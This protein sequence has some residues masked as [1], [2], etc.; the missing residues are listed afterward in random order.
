MLWAIDKKIQEGKIRKCLFITLSGLKD[1][2]LA[3][4]KTEIP[5]R[6]GIVLK[7]KDH[8]DK[9][10]NKKFKSSKKNLDYDIYISNYESMNTLVELFDDYYF[11]MVI[12]DEAHRVGSPGSNQ[13]K[14]IVK[15]FETA[16]YKYI[17][18]GTINANNLMSFYMPFRFLGADTVPI[19]NYY[20]FR[21][22]YMVSVDPDGRIWVPRPGSKPVVATIIGRISVLFKKEDCMDLPG[23]TYNRLSCEMTGDQKRTYKKAKEDMIIQLDEICNACEYGKECSRTTEDCIN[24]AAF[25]KNSLVLAKKLHQMAS[26]FYIDSYV[27]VSETGVEKPVQNI[28]DFSTNSKMKLLMSTLDNIPDDRKVI[29][30]ATYTHSIEMIVDALRKRYGDVVVPAYGSIDG[31]EAMEEFKNSNKKYMAANTTKMGTGYNA[32]FSNYMIFFDNSFSFVVREQAI[33]RQDRKGQTN[34]VTV[35]DLITTDSIDEHI[36]RVL[37]DKGDLSVR[38]SQFAKVLQ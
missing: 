26:G 20:G 6:S 21:E 29:I 12:L 22:K 24:E 38:L 32:Q 5:H 31:F 30:W 15:K 11:D 35:Y 16:K 1:N 8:A 25:M 9:V 27:E 3:E 10:L 7:S 18:T 17:S 33:G 2:V 14:A 13:T 34:K 36:M 4:I 28:I 23:V 19:A 37:D